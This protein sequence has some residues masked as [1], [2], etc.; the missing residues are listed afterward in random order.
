MFVDFN[1]FNESLVTDTDAL[2]FYIQQNLNGNIPEEYKNVQGRININYN[3]SSSKNS[4][5][6]VLMFA[7][8][9]SL[10]IIIIIF[11]IGKLF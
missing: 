11:I 1:V 8:I 4:S 5:N 10:I 6:S 7:S 9:S 2:C 3:S